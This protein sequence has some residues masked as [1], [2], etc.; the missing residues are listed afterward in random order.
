MSERHVNSL[1]KKELKSTSIDAEKK[2]INTK[3]I[4][5]VIAEIIESGTPV[6]ILTGGD[7]IGQRMR[8]KER[9]IKEK[10][11]QCTDCNKI[12]TNSNGFKNHIAVKA[13]FK[14]K[15]GTYCRECDKTYSTPQSLIRHMK[16]KTHIKNAGKSIESK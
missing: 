14:P 7:L 4:G 8:Y 2:M 16:T 1:L 10:R 11:F 6:S 13:C 3:R 15:L 9:V 12:F 5:E